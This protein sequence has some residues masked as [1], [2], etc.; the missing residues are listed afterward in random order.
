MIESITLADVATF[1]PLKQVMNEL[2]TF[3]F[4]FGANGTGKTTISRVIAAD[5][6]HGGCSVTWKRGT[7]LQTLVY[8][9][10]FVHA[11][12]SQSSELKGIFTLGEKSIETMDKIAAVKGELD[13]IG[14]KIETLTINLQGSD[15]AGGKKGELAQVETDFKEACWA[16]KQKHDTKFADAFGGVRGD[17]ERFKAR[18]LD[19]RTTNI[20][21]LQT[22]DDLTKR[23]SSVFG[24]TPTRENAV[25][26]VDGTQLVG[27]ESDS[28]LSKVVVGKE[29]VDITAMIRRLTNSDWVREGR[30]FYD[31][32][33]G[34]CP[35]CQQSTDASFAESLNAYFDETFVRDS[36]AIDALVAGYRADAG[37]LQSQVDAVI[38]SSSRFLDI[39]KL[40][41]EKSL[42][43][44][45]I[46]LNL[47]H[48][49]TKRAEPSRV[50]QLDSISNVVSEIV[51]LVRVANV[52]VDEHNT[53]VANHTQVKRDLTAQVWRYLLD[54]ELKHAINTYDNAR[55][56]ATKAIDGMSAALDKLEKEKRDKG[57]ELRE[58]EKKTTSVQP[59]VTS[60]NGLLRSFG[61]RGF[62]LAVSG[63]DTS[64]RLVRPGDVDARETLSEGER[65]FVT[66]LYF[67]SLIKGSD[68]ESGMTTD[69]IVVFDDPVS[70]L[71]SD[72]LF[73]V[74]SLIKGLFDDVR[75]GAG[76]IK[77]VFVLTHNVY[78]HK[79]V[80]FNPKRVNDAMNE[81]TF[82][83]VRKSTDGSRAEKHASNPVRTAY[84]LLWSEVRSSTRSNLTIQNTLRRI[85]ENYFKIFGRVDPDDLCAMFEGHERVVCR[86]LFSW[87]NDGSHFAHDDLYLTVDDAT[88]DAYLNVFMAIFDKSGHVS[89]YNMMMGI[90]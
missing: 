53:M 66:F 16:Q 25:P 67:Y 86:S 37:R 31:V 71:D 89:H 87:V 74:G 19:E 75:N 63:T 60:I 18:T 81:E 4:V 46:A 61:F 3:N 36:Q 65:T 34:A 1:G 76:H 48:L 90:S 80:T 88:V 23:A 73:I 68:S 62:S 30:R 72:I 42:L 54:V 56:A 5:G 77:Q 70:S 9:R 28:I 43:D 64:Y 78:F 12:F 84:E 52:A 49:A 40:K 59:T 44:T 10:D 41:V 8:N 79:E 58:L 32:N 45:T 35:F 7:R 11:N 24:P 26:T 69:R 14:K 57:A 82:W 51:E 13:Q 6:K 39:E 15:G 21:A 38:A 55:G 83:V 29:D 22:F 20:A 47:Q 27:R 2:S 33:D 17:K 50:V 85:L